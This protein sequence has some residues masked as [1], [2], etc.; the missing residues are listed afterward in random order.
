MESCLDDC[1]GRVSFGKSGSLG[2]PLA[3]IV[4]ILLLK[5]YCCSILVG[6]DPLERSCWSE[7]NRFLPS[8]AYAGMI[9]PLRLT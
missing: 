3:V 8:S 9:L 2:R 7:K 1:V 4:L 6:S 5:R